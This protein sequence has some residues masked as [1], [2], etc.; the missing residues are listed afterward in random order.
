MIVTKAYKFR[1]YPNE[2]QRI[3]I[4]KT[5][6][7]SNLVY[8]KLLDKKKANPKLSKYDLASFIPGFKQELE[9]LKEVDS[10]L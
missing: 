9:F 4:N 3:L 8:N 2:K 6:G 10:V 1:M 7:C 5:F